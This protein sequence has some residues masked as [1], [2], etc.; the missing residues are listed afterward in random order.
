MR[1]YD[2]TARC[3]N[4]PGSPLQMRQ[5]YANI[6]EIAKRRILNDGIFY[7]IFL[8]M[9]VIDDVL[10]KVGGGGEDIGS[11][12]WGKIPSDITERDWV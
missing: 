3:Y 11:R 10:A 8:Q 12:P 9:K 2:E 1:N 5:H 6:K 4:E 7:S